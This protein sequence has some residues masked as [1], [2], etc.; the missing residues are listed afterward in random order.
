MERA[1]DTLFITGVNGVPHASA[2]EM[3]DCMTNQSAGQSVHDERLQTS[4]SM[5]FI[6]LSKDSSACHVK[7]TL[8]VQLM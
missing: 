7:G 2:K 6:L 5:N 1:K 8:S 4:C 3:V